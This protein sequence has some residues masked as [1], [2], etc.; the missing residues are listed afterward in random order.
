MVRLGEP[1][2]KKRFALGR[3]PRIGLYE[4]GLHGGYRSNVIIRANGWC[5]QRVLVER[6]FEGWWYP[7]IPRYLVHSK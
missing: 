3:K 1:P 6:V 5:C 2:V 7:N 4:A